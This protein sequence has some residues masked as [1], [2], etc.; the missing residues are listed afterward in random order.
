MGSGQSLV[1]CHYST[2]DRL[3]HLGP[4]GKMGPDIPVELIV[5]QL[6]VCRLCREYMHRNIVARRSICMHRPDQKILSFFVR[7][8]SHFGRE[9]DVHGSSKG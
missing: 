9:G 8:Y 2:D 5:Q 7:K 3:S 4:K 6:L 1:S